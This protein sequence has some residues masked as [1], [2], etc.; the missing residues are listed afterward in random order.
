MRSSIVLWTSL[1]CL[2]LFPCLV[3]ADTLINPGFETGDIS[4]WTWVPNSPSDSYSV[5]TGWTGQTLTYTPPEGQYFLA[6]NSWIG[7]EVY[8]D[9]NL[10]A[11]QQLQGVA[12]LDNASSEFSPGATL[13]N[14]Q[15]LQGGNPIATPWSV[16]ETDVS[17]NTSG[18]WTDW[19]WTAP[20]SGTYRLAYETYA[21]NA[22]S[23]EYGLFDAQP[24]PLPEPGTCA[25]LLMGLPGVALLRRRRK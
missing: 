19:S 10:T 7:G 11:G 3:H 20:S 15:V 16:T 22:N 4:G 5:V 2:V 18:P 25:L 6:I 8:Q 12:A 9:V 17:G 13:A 24:Q 21:V 1:V 14:V 23:W